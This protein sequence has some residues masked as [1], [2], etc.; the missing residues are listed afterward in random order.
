MRLYTYRLDVRRVID[1]DTIEANIDLGFNMLHKCSIRVYGVNC[2]EMKTAE[3]KTAKQYTEQW[4]EKYK[5]KL[6]VNVASK[7]DKYGRA[8]AAVL[9]VDSEKKETHL[10]SSDLIRDGHGIVYKPTELPDDIQAYDGLQIP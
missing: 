2:P 5:D 10:L 7:A 1:G 3:G 8:L 6:I 9:A 4:I